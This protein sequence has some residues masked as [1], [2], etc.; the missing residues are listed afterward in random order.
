MS[1]QIEDNGETLRINNDKQRSSERE[2]Y[3]HRF[4]EG[5]LELMIT[6]QGEKRCKICSTELSKEQVCL[7]MRFITGEV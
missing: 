5:R 6:E 7:L 3:A 4:P 2:L 1:H